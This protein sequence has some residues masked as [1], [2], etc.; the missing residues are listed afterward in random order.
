MRKESP[1]ALVPAE[2]QPESKRERFLRVCKPRVEQ[3][4]RR[5]HMIGKMGRNAS[6]YDYD[7]EDIDKIT[8]R[9]RA[10]IDKLGQRMARADKPAEF[11]F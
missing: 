6:E 9:L 5:I 1:V 8:E 10:E 2:K 3:A 7:V 4:I 11:K